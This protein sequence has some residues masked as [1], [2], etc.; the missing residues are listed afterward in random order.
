ML[1]DRHTMTYY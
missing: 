1:P